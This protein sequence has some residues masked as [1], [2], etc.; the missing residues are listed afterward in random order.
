MFCLSLE[1]V[2][3]SFKQIIKYTEADTEQIG[4]EDEERKKDF[5]DEKRKPAVE[6]E[7]AKAV[8]QSKLKYVTQQLQQINS[9]VEKLKRDQQHLRMSCLKL[10][11]AIESAIREAAKQVTEILLVYDQL[12]RVLRVFFA[13]LG[14]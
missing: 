12:P 13:I 2:L 8:T 4:Q 10:G 14:R 6:E 11:T 5:E 3:F 9:V 1:R 7:R